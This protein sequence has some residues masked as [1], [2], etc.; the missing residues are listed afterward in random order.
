MGVRH[1]RPVTRRHP[2]RL[3]LLDAELMSTDPNVAEFYRRSRWRIGTLVHD[4]ADHSRRG[5][6]VKRGGQQWVSRDKLPMVRWHGKIDS[7]SVPWDSIEEHHTARV[8]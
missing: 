7:V 4:T 6:I 8:G 2:L 5:V 1:A 3:R